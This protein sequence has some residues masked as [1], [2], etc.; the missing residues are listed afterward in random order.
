MSG[1]DEIL[2]VIK[3][4]QQENEKKILDSANAKADEIKAESEIK[5]AKVYDDCM[6]RSKEQQERNFENSCS[7]VDALMKRKLLAAKVE[8][9]DAVIEN[10][11]KKLN[12]L[13]DKD[14]F[15]FIGKLVGQH[16]REG[17]GELSL[18]KRDLERMPADFEEK[19]NE[20]AFRCKGSIVISDVPADIEDGFILR[21][22]LVSENCGFKAVIEAEE[23]NVR[24]TAAKILFGQVK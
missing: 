6:K 13:P 3:K 15:E 23:D 17:R 8:M 20:Q 7:S 10:V 24:D 18:S 14:Y 21:Y 1:L 4:E 9:V 19:L 12:S 5:A 16:I 11:I 22:G 2:D